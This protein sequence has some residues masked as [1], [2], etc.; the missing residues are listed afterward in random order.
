MM[1]P[2][3]IDELFGKPQ[4]KGIG[5]ARVART[6]ST[7]NTKSHVKR[8]LGSKE[9]ADI[10]QLPLE[11]QSR[12][13]RTNTSDLGDTV[14][15]TPA[16][17]KTTITL[18]RLY[19]P[20][21][22]STSSLRP[23][24][25]YNEFKRSVV[26]R[27]NEAISILECGLVERADWIKSTKQET[28]TQPVFSVKLSS[29]RARLLG[30]IG[31]CNN[32]EAKLDTMLEKKSLSDKGKILVREARNKCRVTIEIESN[33]FLESLQ[34]ELDTRFK[35]ASDTTL[36]NIAK[37]K[38]RELNTI[39]SRNMRELKTDLKYIYATECSVSTRSEPFILKSDKLKELQDID[40]DLYYKL[41]DTIRVKQDASLLSFEKAMANKSNLDALRKSYIEE[42]D[43]NKKLQL[44]KFSFD[45]ARRSRECRA[46]LIENLDENKV[47]AMVDV[48]IS[49]SMCCTNNIASVEWNKALADIDM[50]YESIHADPN[51]WDIF[52]TLLADYW[53]YL[54]CPLD[55][56]GEYLHIVRM[57]ASLSS[58][59]HIN[60]ASIALDAEISRLRDRIEHLLVEVKAIDKEVRRACSLAT[61][62][63]KKEEYSQALELYNPSISAE[64]TRPVS[65]TFGHRS[66][67]SR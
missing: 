55:R 2:E 22:R 61:K 40:R 4:P 30:T 58:L 47:A 26:A 13:Q 54:G 46:S 57:Y 33:E 24:E 12:K 42:L 17:I 39:A 60:A 41:L 66:Y 56:Q 1:E 15:I 6:C 23:E 31:D 10:T 65:T 67:I 7:P 21:I 5:K 8:C 48:Y 43:R 52:T 59:N 37:D 36:E 16:Y 3:D 34:H 35:N 38:D 25:H 45:C 50:S 28:V 27:H 20:T 64:V 32:V 14:K 29:S 49:K 62:K 11:K 53:S 63:V 18:P 9:P 51:H 19:S 44:K